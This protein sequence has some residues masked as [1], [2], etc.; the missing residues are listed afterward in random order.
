MRNYIDQFYNEGL[1]TTFYLKPI[2]WI[3]KKIENKNIVSIIK[4]LIKVIYTI[5]MIL[6]A[7]FMFYVKWPL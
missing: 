6:F 1:A 4:V 2:K 7:I 5:L 3:D